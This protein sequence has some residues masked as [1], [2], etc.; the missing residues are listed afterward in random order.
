MSYEIIGWR[1]RPAQ[2]ASDA[3][4]SRRRQRVSVYSP[5]VLTSHL[6]REHPRVG[7]SRPRLHRL[8][9]LP[10]ELLPLSRT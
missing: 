8:R 4:P 7:Y 2:A 9:A 6:D 10:V 3:T 5:F 1:A